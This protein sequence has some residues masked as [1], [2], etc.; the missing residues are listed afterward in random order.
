MQETETLAKFL[1]TYGG[2]ALL[3]ITVPFLLAVIRSLYKDTKTNYEARLAEQKLM[4]EQHL[5]IIQ[6]Q[7]DIMQKT[8]VALI[9]VAQA[10][11]WCKEKN[12]GT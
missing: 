3:I 12:R 4:D 1:Q 8:E 9:R 5:P 6:K 7:T 11:E 10:I 2:W